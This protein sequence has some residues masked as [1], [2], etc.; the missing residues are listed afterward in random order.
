MTACIQPLRTDGD[1]LPDLR[2]VYALA[3]MA[4]QAVSQ[5]LKCIR[6]AA[7]VC[8]GGAEAQEECPEDTL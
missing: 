2:A 7:E 3:P 6:T 5:K 1:P 4:F 8:Y